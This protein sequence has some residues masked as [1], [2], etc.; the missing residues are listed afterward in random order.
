MQGKLIYETRLFADYSQLALS[1]KVGDDFA[2]SHDLVR[3]ARGVLDL[4]AVAL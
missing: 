3:R 2:S 4:A 1:I